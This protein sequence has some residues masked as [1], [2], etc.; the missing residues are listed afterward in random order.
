VLVLTSAG[1]GE[2]KTTAASNLAVTLT[3]I[4]RKVLLIDADLRRPRL[5][6]IFDISNDRGLS[7]LLQA[8][9][10]DVFDVMQGIVR[11]TPVRNLFV[12]PAGPPVATGVLHS[13]LLPAL[14]RRFRKE[15]DMVLIDTP[16]V[17]Q[18]PD[19]RVVARQADAAVLVVKSGTTTRDAA[20]AA[21]D[22]LT[23]DGARILGT[24]LNHWNP[25]KSPSGYY[26]SSNGYGY[27]RADL[28]RPSEAV[29]E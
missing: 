8:K 6:E 3:E 20:I 2:G 22:R 19:A 11:E 24:V 5:H 16:P 13:A 21:A 28:N 26:G 29:Q 12:L 10:T 25:K 9:A 23:A 17:L 14:L 7:D 4:R 27:Y 15:F 18:M 1:P